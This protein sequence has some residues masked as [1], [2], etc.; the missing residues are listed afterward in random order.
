MSLNKN[1]IDKIK[2]PDNF[3]EKVDSIVNKAYK[4]K[5]KPKR[6]GK[7]VAIA[8][9][10]AFAISSGLIATNPEYVEA[11]INKI[12]EVFKTRNYMVVLEDGTKTFDGSY[13]VNHMGVDIELD[14]DT[15]VT[16]V[17]KITEKLDSSN[18]KLEDL[19]IT[20]DDSIA[21]RVSADISYTID[22][23]SIS[24]GSNMVKNSETS[25][26]METK[27]R[28]PENLIGKKDLNIEVEIENLIIVGDYALDTKSK[29][30]N[31]PL[32]ATKKESAVKYIPID[33]SYKASGL[34]DTELSEL[35][36]H[37]DG[38]VELLYDF[39]SH[40]DKDYKITRFIIE[41]EDGTRLTG[42]ASGNME[43]EFGSKDK[44]E[45]KWGLWK[46][47]YNGKITGDTLKVIPVVTH[48]T[49]KNIEV[50]EDESI[51][52]EIQPITVKLK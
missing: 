27:I 21:K 42:G 2:L 15:S 19:G 16:G 47:E 9:G 14:I 12:M 23:E 40:K 20:E 30:L 13:K 6:T 32:K 38:Y 7:K 5:K 49:N 1:D 25:Y 17:I 22:G 43:G 11:T 3:D 45:G 46:K 37:P 48:N 24:Y 31:I 10:L 26:E 35:I 18:I 28:I 52:K 51:L 41:N 29:T 44:I 36:V 33:Y 39:G 50:D 34:R 8:A 4:E